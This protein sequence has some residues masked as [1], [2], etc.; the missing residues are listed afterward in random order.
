MIVKFV[1][2]HQEAITMKNCELPNC[3]KCG[4]ERAPRAKIDQVEA[5]ADYRGDPY[6]HTRERVYLC[7]PCFQKQDEVVIFSFAKAREIRCE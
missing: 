3:H 7:G 4:D 2:Y 6:T 1:R 5:C